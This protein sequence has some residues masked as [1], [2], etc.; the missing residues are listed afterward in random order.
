MDDTYLC[1]AELIVNGQKIV[2]QADHAH[3]EQ[4]VTEALNNSCNIAFAQMAQK[5]GQEQLLKTAKAFFNEG[6]LYSDLQ[7]AKSSGHL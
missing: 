7:L 3:G 2:D 5:V 4:T 1:E 6:V